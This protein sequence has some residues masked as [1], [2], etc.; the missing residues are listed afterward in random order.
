MSQLKEMT[1][2][3]PVVVGFDDTEH[4]TKAVEYAVAEAFA[5]QVPLR[6]VHVYRWIPAPG[7]P[8][9]PFSDIPKD[10]VRAAVVDRLEDA[11]RRL[12]VEH[13]GLVVETEPLEGD[14]PVMLARAARGASL[15]VVGGRGHGGFAGLLL[16]STTLRV[17]PMAECPVLVVRGAEVPH[18]G[19][20]MVGI[21]LL[22]A[23]K[24]TDALEFAFAEAA[25]RKAEV[26]A[27]SVWEDPARVLGSYARL[28]PQ[29]F[30]DYEGLQRKHL[31][32]IVAPF[33][34]KHPDVVVSQ[35]AFPGTVSRMLVDSTRLVDALVIG[36][37][38]SH[39]AKHP[40]MKVGALAHIV[41]HHAHCPVFIVPE[42]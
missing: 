3:E 9:M 39:P 40:G 16:G 28:T 33:Q 30:P 12:R 19:R 35:Q 21:D 29:T 42:H 15:L 41:L 38:A 6:L 10:E 32:S 22:S 8:G 7:A 34:D 27:V 4:S 23:R 25:R 2:N 1:V 18:T 26:Y 24:S 13:P 37:D 17:L 20:I 31:A 11:A 5:R 36:G 14:P